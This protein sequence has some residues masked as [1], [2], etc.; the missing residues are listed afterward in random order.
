MLRAKVVLSAVLV[1]G[2]VAGCG[3]AA[4]ARQPPSPP[5][6]AQQTEQTSHTDPS[7]THRHSR[8]C[9][10]LTPNT[11]VGA[12]ITHRGAALVLTTSDDVATLRR[13]A[14]DMTASVP[15]QGAGA[16]V[17][18]IQHG[19]RLVFEPGPADDLTALQHGVIEHARQV[20]KGCGLV[21]AAVSDETAP[22]VVE[23]E[24]PRHAERSAP[25][26]QSKPKAKKRHKPDEP[27][28]DAPT[29]KKA[30]KSAQKTDAKRKPVPADKPKPDS[31]KPKVERRPKQDKKPQLPR[32]PGAPHPD[33]IAP[34]A[35]QSFDF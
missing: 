14:A 24:Q 30:S 32:L 1:C 22:R 3:A 12:Q 35:G 18:N 20:A 6:V 31:D 19:V 5:S 15:S 2:G 11:K 10:A 29:P 7:A 23:P 4:P 17:D 33:P 16:R 9:A 27:K 28:A 25:A 21:L 8:L 34:A 26:K 13:R